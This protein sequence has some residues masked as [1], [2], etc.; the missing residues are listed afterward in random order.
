M[1][2]AGAISLT[3]TDVN[4]CTGNATITIIN[5]NSLT[6]QITQQP[7]LCDGQITLDAGTGYQNY[8]WSNGSNSQTLSITQSGVFDLTVSDANGCS[9]VTSF[10]AVLPQQSALSITGGGIICAGASALLVANAGFQSYL[11]SNN[12]SLRQIT[13]STPGIYTVTATDSNGC[14]TIANATI[15][16]TNP[17]QVQ[18]TGSTSICN[19]SAAQL[20]ANNVFQSYAWS[21]GESSQSISV[22]TAGAISLTVTDANG[23]TSN[24]TT[25]IINSNSLTPQITQQPYLCDGQITLDA[26]ASYQNYTWSNGSNSPTIDITQSGV[27][28]LTVSDANGCSGT[29]SSSVTVPILEVLSLSGIN[30]ICPGNA[31]NLNASTNFIS[32]VWT[33]GST[34][35]SIAVS[36]S[37]IYSIT[38]TDANGCIATESIS[39]SLGAVPIVAISG[40]NVI[41]LGSSTILSVSNALLFSTINWSSGQSGST[42]TVSSASTYGVTATAINGCTSA[43]SFQVSV[44]NSLAPTINEG[45]YNCDQQITLLAP[46]GFQGYQW[47]NGAGAPSISVNSDG[48]YSLTVTD[49]TGCTGTATTFVNVPDDL[50]VVVQTPPTPICPGGSA[51]LSVPPGLASYTWSNGANSNAITTN[52][53]GNYSVTVTDL[54]GCTAIGDYTFSF[55]DLPTVSITGDPI[56]DCSSTPTELT[57]NITNGIPPNSYVWSSGDTTA[58]LQTSQEATY[59]T[60]VTDINGCTAATQIE[61]T[62]LSSFNTFADTLEFQ[63]GQV[64]D[65]VPPDAIFNVASITWTPASILNCANCQQVEA[66]PLQDTRVDFIAEALGDCVLEGYFFLLSKAKTGRDV[67]APN[68]INPNSKDNFG[69]T[70]YGDL[71]LQINFL[72]IY[73]RWG[74]LVDEIRNPTPGDMNQGWQGRFRNSPAQLG[75]YAWVAEVVFADGK[76]ELLY[77]DLTLVK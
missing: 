16:A 47:S 22:N 76:V 25:T 70:L 68:I 20:S 60:T 61:V 17:V 36:D 58:T 6:P 62:A 23:C 50:I 21:T 19:G 31:T 42:I 15:A 59:S 18:I 51:Q 40:S 13:V 10:N 69:F 34:Q 54:Y 14:T 46:I 56:I 26:G 7:Y 55:A 27:F 57:V 33:T 8:T 39:V 44:G 52:L 2:T 73:T 5:S 65:L 49:G 28:D 4:G 72:R 37:G 48:S 1:N 74:E 30:V 64:L 35:S 53:S 77:G 3:V 66:R 45:V 43:T 71:V 41:C 38:A 11:W 12:T 29:A 67:L 24:A 9:G 75:V 63:P 32:Y